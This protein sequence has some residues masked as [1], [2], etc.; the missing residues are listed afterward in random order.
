[1]EIRNRRHIRINSDIPAVIELAGQPAM[2]V[3][4][5]DLSEGGV[6]IATDG[7]VAC[8]LCP[9]DQSALGPIPDLTVDLRFDLETG[10]ARLPV[11]ACCRALF[12]A[13]LSQ[14]HFT[15]GCQFLRI[16][17]DTV[18]ALGEFILQQVVVLFTA[19][20]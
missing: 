13:R 7:E 16:E 1:M 18:N 20:S 17:T 14:D 9:R 2:P 19:C 10:N 8:C 6:K 3:R 4:V 15:F 12:L 11:E 5:V